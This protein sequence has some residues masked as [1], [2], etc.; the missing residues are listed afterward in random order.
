MSTE[1]KKPSPEATILPAPE[2]RA[3]ADL[4]RR[5]RPLMGKA[6]GSLVIHEIYRSLQGES[7]F[8]GLPC[9][10]I[11]LTACHL[12]CVYC[13]TPHAFHEGRVVVLED[14][15]EQA[16]ALGDD[17]VEITGGEPLLQAE[18]FPLMSRLAD[19]GK[20]VLL[21]TS[22]AVDTSRVDPRVRIILDLKTPGSGEESAN[23]WHNLDRLKRIDEVKLVLCDRRDFDWAVAV[24]REHRI[25]ERC[26]VLFSAVAGKV[27]PTEL[28]AWILETR[29]PI[30][31]QLQLHKIL[32]DPMARGV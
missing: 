29:L 2:S 12:R 20:T 22:G 7:T 25:L 27:N 23:V 3:G 8:A 16:L 21:E 11:R 17:L 28:A 31:L 26:P 30:R 32:W 15:V 6:A 9:V 14:V 5:L 4:A 24:V 13:D 1:V 18:V 19:L 10:F